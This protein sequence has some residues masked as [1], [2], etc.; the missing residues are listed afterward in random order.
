MLINCSADEAV[1]IRPSTTHQECSEAVDLLRINFRRALGAV[2]NRKGS[3][4]GR[5]L[6]E[7][8][9]SIEFMGIQITLEYSSANQLAQWNRNLFMTLDFP[10]RSQMPK[11]LKQ[12]MQDYFQ[13]VW[14]LNH[15][16][17]I[18]EVR[19]SVFFRT[20]LCSQARREEELE[21]CSSNQLEDSVLIGT[22]ARLS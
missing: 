13:T 2:H 10:N 11:E 21:L 22:R 16:I 5:A 17:D 1:C 3:P 20:L 15:G 18:H 8:C 7:G 9:S 12:R 6:G 4:T 19:R 14:S